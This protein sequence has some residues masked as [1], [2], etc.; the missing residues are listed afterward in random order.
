M[1]D[2]PGADIAT[3][4]SR[5]QGLISWC[6]LLALTFAF[7]PAARSSGSTLPTLG[8]VANTGFCPDGAWQGGIWPGG[9]R[10]EG[11]YT[12]GSFCSF[13]DE[14]VGYAESQEFLAPPA[15]NLYLA[16]YPGLPGRRLI[17]KNV[18][19][20]QETELRPQS[21]PG[22]EWH[23]N[24]LPVPPEWLGKRVQFIAEDRSTENSG[25]LAFSLP[26]LPVSSLLSPIDT[27]SPQGGFCPNGVYQATKWQGVRPPGIVTWG[28]Y[29]K[30]GDADTGW[31][32]SPPFIADSYVS[33][34][35]AG[36]A[37]K[38][39]LRL[40]VENLQVGRQ[41]P[42]QAPNPS[43]EMWRLHHFR[44][45]DEWSGQSVRIV[46]WDQATG[47]GGW[48]AF[49]EPVSKGWKADAYPAARMFALFL[50]LTVVLLIP[51]IAACMLAA[52]RGMEDL[53]DLTTIAFLALGLTGYAAFW[54]YFCSPILGFIFSYTGFLA[55]CAVIAYLVSAKSRRLKLRPAKQLIAPGTLVL[56]ASLF[57][58]SLGMLYNMEGNPL[59]VA[60]A[61]FGPP[62][63]PTLY[64]D[65]T[66]PKLFADGVHS[67]HIPKPLGGGWL[68]SDRPPLQTG[69]ALWTY[70]WTSGNRDL[71][72][73]V[74]SVVLQCSFL[75]ALWSFLIACNIDRR[76]MALAIA[77]CFLSG[78]TLLNS[79]FVWPKLFPVAYLLI[80]TAY[81][82]TDRYYQVRDRT[83]IG[84]MLGATVA[85][86]MLGHGGS[87]FAILGVAVCMLLLRR[88]PSRRFLIGMAVG[89]V[90]L[91]SPWML[92][93]KLYDPPGDRLLKLHL[94]GIVEP[95]P[96]ASLIGLILSRY[97]SLKA[98]ELVQYK[99]SN[100]KTV[101]GDLPQY[102]AEAQIFCTA[103]VTG[104]VTRRNTAAALLQQT[105]F[106]YWIPSI[107][108]AILGPLALMLNMSRRCR[109]AESI[110]ASRIW[111][112]TGVILVL[113]CL[114]MFGPDSTGTRQ[115]TYLT[116]ILAFSGSCLAFWALRPWL[117]VALT[118]AHIL[119]NAVLFVWLTPVLPPPG[120]SE[121]RIYWGADT[122]PINIFL[123][124][125]CLM[126]AAAI[127]SLLASFAR[128][129]APSVERLR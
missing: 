55:S 121:L 103:L 23:F 56:L 43:G 96:E 94:A 92:Y 49:S 51:S 102:L 97:S 3:L 12:W 114:V 66:I 84:A 65:N 45:P 100:F 72:Y 99:V 87:M 93:Q 37:G 34:Y 15:L 129:P 62:G 41:L 101:A 48:L 1:R 109:R 74:L 124:A 70:A 106:F 88:Y 19:S 22:D 108:L 46:A 35:T 10:P 104:S 91:Y 60:S 128:Q 50:M 78:F 31:T 80:L 82:L 64:G 59:F 67:G 11:L 89:A 30:S 21:T 53:L 119:W 111:L 14:D 76:P 113:W 4:T 13:G 38:P 98:S 18:E 117:A 58:V 5:F 16:G 110:A 32:A 61:R 86:A 8:L 127:F 116:E 85:F 57:I 26:F 71:A 27:T 105:T 25:W 79:F 77:T 120:S 20:G 107:G 63:P 112:L 68:S 6:A 83:A 73:E 90:L 122:G 95:R 81:L 40:A 54:V 126:S 7:T 125:A 115:G 44:L 39:G 24:T 47:L 2:S 118:A 33:I 17:L 75:A 123:G 9:R 36:Y 42:L 28:S 52:F 69:N 29:C